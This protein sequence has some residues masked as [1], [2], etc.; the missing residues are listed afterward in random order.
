MMTILIIGL[1]GAFGVSLV[2]FAFSLAREDGALTE[3]LQKLEEK[4]ATDKKRAEIMTEARTDDETID[5][6]DR[7]TF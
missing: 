4:A 7:G 5:R 1:L 3:R 6:L 2:I